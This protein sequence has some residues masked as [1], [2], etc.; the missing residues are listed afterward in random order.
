MAGVELETCIRA[1]DEAG[2]RGGNE[3]TSLTELRR[4]QSTDEVLA[5]LRAGGGSGG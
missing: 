4:W 3:E 1:P 5:T 2:A